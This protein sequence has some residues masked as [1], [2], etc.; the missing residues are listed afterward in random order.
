[1]TRPTPAELAAV[2][3]PI[4]LRARTRRA[5]ILDP[6]REDDRVLAAEEGAERGSRARKVGRSRVFSP[7]NLLTEIA[8]L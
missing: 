4:L 5:A 7:G 3:A 8:R 2:G 6:F 1:M